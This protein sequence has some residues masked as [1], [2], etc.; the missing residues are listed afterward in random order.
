MDGG[1]TAAFAK[2]EL[3]GAKANENAGREGAR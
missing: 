1:L 2:K 3:D